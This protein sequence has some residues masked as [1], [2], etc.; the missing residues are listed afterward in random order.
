M[1]EAEEKLGSIRINE[2]GD[3]QL[4]VLL[5]FKLHSQLRFDEANVEPQVAYLREL[6]FELSGVHARKGTWRS[7]EN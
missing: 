7:N 2:N 3:S 6:E 5:E 1:V 4:H